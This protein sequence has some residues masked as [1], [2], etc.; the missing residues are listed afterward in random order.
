ML[1]RA[2]TGLLFILSTLMLASCSDDAPAPPDASPDAEPG[3]I[4]GG[5]LDGGDLDSG[6]LDGGDLDSGIDSGTSYVDSGADAADVDGQAPSISTRRGSILVSEVVVTTAD[7]NIPVTQGGPGG[8]AGQ[9]ISISFD[10]LTTGGVPPAYA[11]PGIP[12][13]GCSVWIYTV[14]T[15]AEHAQVDEGSI[16]IGSPARGPSGIIDPSGNP[17]PATPCAFDIEAH[18]YGCVSGVGPASA[19]VTSNSNG[20]ATYTIS[21]LPPRDRK[22]MTLEIDGFDDVSNNGLF[23]VV[24]S[25]GSAITVSNPGATSTTAAENVSYAFY[26]GAGPVPLLGGTIDFLTDGGAGTAEPVR[27]QKGEGAT[28][29]AF[30]VILRP[31]G[32]GMLL[33]GTQPHALPLDGTAA[34]FSC[35]GGSCGS[36]FGPISGLVIRGRTTSAPVPAHP[37]HAMPPFSAM[38]EG[39]QYA[40]F[41]CFFVGQTEATIPAEAMATILSTA[42]TRIE[43]RVL[44]IGAS[45]QIADANRTIV[46]VGHGFVGHTTVP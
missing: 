15:D 16:D 14:G 33:T 35:G 41:Q 23:P 26:L 6:D 37:D 19:S 32:Q 44:Q 11:D 27:I 8:I 29:P 45:F 31:E 21:G 24:A 18:E 20:T 17:I 10:D 9:S 4:D 13:S 30:D 39:Q 22:G 1:H 7:A 43:T 42:P 46:E 2:S 28:L 5:D 12:T 38:L 40:T 36:K 25:A 3:A 34:T